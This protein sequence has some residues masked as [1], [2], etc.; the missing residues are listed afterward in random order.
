LSGQVV[1]AVEVFDP[2]N[3]SFREELREQQ[4]LKKERSP[5]SAVI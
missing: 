2:A 3:D 1:I 5:A 4:K